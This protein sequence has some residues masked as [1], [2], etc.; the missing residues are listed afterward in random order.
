MK[1]G[2]AVA[3]LTLVA[4]GTADS[5]APKAFKV[6]DKAVTA[7]DLISGYSS[8]Q[9]AA[10]RDYENVAL[11]VSGDVALV[12]EDGMVMLQTSLGPRVVLSVL[13]G[14]EKTLIELKAGQL[15]QANCQ[16]TV[17]YEGSVYLHDCRPATS[18]LPAA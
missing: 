16:S 6:P 2:I 3:C 18:P 14:S 9:M 11:Q 8:N 17:F 4:C 10:K 1:N 15:F 13:P 7:D 5:D 12:G